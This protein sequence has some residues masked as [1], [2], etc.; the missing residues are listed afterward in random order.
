MKHIT[1]NDETTLCGR[2]A[3]ITCGELC[4]LHEALFDDRMNG[5]RDYCV[6]CAAKF[7]QVSHDYD[8]TERNPEAWSGGI[9]ENH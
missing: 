4:D 3:D 5:L 6:E 2:D 1:E 7:P 9:A 8:W